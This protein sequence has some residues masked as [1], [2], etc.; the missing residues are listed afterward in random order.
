MR[1]HRLVSDAG[2]I[3]WIKIFTIYKDG[4]AIG[5]KVLYKKGI[6]YLVCHMNVTVWVTQLRILLPNINGQQNV[7]T[8]KL[9][10]SLE[11]KKK[12]QCLPDESTIT[13]EQIITIYLLHAYLT[14]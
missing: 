13:K 6:I 10:I 7:C 12:K 9:I 2:T 5:K 3:V 11:R 4:L 1:L 8:A 14:R